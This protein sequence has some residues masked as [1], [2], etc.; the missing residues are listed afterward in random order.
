MIYIFDLNFK[1]DVLGIIFDYLKVKY[2]LVECDF[3]EI[4]DLKNK[5]FSSPKIIS[6]NF[7][8]SNILEIKNETFDL[9]YE[10]FKI[11]ME[12]EKLNFNEKSILLL[13]SQTRAVN[14]YK[15]IKDVFDAKVY[16]ASITEDQD[17]KLK[18]GDRKI[19]KVEI[20]KM[21]RADV[22]INTTYL[23]ARNAE[24]TCMLTD[25]SFIDAEIV[26]DINEKPIKT[27]LLRRYEL[28]GAKIY[29]GIL[30]EIYK[31]LYIL[32]KIEDKNYY[33][34]AHEIYDNVLEKLSDTRI[35]E[36]IEVL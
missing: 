12:N 33:N 32:S 28:M 6:R 1:Y 21:K 25:S 10:S 20:E 24:N 23:G 7:E 4:N 13:G 3:D 22:I 34:L 36:K 2:S 8:K 27:T 18:V 26:I 17:I 16:I 29:P 14:I 30:I 11:F 5:Y 31:C 19:K 9:D 35:N 15:A